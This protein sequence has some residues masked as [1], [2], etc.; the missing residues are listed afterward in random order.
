MIRLLT[1]GL[2]TLNWGLAWAQTA[3]E[4]AVAIVATS[5][6]GRLERT[7][8]TKI[9][10]VEGE[11]LFPGDR[12]QAT[13]TGIEL[14][15]CMSG[16]RTTLSAG[17]TVE[18][19][20][21]GAARKS[22]RVRDTGPAPFCPVPDVTL[23]E[24]EKRRFYGLETL[25]SRATPDAGE[26]ERLEPPQQAALDAE[27]AAIRQTDAAPSYL[28]AAAEAATLAKYGLHEQAA[29]AYR[30]LSDESA[31]VWSRALVY[32][33]HVAS[34]RGVGS[35]ATGNGEGQIYSVLVGINKYPLLA[36]Q[37]LA[38]AIQDARTF[39]D[40]LRSPRGGSV[41]AANVRLL[42]DENATTAAIREGIREV[43]QDRAGPN[44]TAIFFI[45][46]HAGVERKE[47]YILTYDTKPGELPDTALTMREIR[48]LLDVALPNVGNVLIFIDVCHSGQID[49]FKNDLRRVPEF[50][51]R[52]E[53]QETFGILASD[54]DEEAWESSSY[55]NGHG[56]F[57]YFLLQGLNGEADRDSDGR[58]SVGELYFYVSDMVRKG[59]RENQHPRR[60]G[61][62]PGGHLL[63]VNLD[64]AGISLPGWKVPDQFKA[65][66]SGAAE[67]PIPPFTLPATVASPD[68]DRFLKALGEDRL[69]GPDPEAAMELL[70]R[71]R[72]STLD[73]LTLRL[74]ENQLRIALQDRGQQ[75]LLT[76]LGGEEEPQ[77]QDAFE[78]GA[79]LFE[80]AWSL[81]QDALT[82]RSRAWFC[83]ARAM[84]F[85][86]RYDE[87][88][89]LLE[90]ALR[91]EQNAPYLYNALGLLYLQQADYDRSIAAFNDAIRFAP[92]W[93]YPRH[94][95]AL[96][97]TQ[98]GRTEEAIAVY[99]DALQAAP[100]SWF[101][102]Y[103]LGLVQQRI[104]LLRDAEESFRLALSLAP[105]R[106][107]PETA[108]GYLAAYRGHAGD[109]ELFYRAAMA[110]QPTFIPA[111]H[112]LAL[113]LA[114]EG[115][116]PE[117]IAL[118][119]D[120]LRQDPEFYASRLA[121]AGAL[122]SS[123]R[124]EDSLNEY[125]RVSS[126]DPQLVAAS[127]AAAR[128][129]IELD[130][131]PEAEREM[132]TVLA[133]NAQNPAA[134]E[135]LGDALA[136]QARVPDAVDAYRRAAALSSRS[137]GRRLDHKAAELR[138]RRN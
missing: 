60:T 53:G 7:A 52:Y 96:A 8:E 62:M 61:D 84:L 55:G 27:L 129:L 11:L 39:Y 68:V 77:V 18:I 99:R 128:V 4:S 106:P 46:A 92:H 59:T 17:A 135:I 120:I 47:P 43:L 66:Q 38:F 95:L 75:I 33:E 13:G 90:R 16:R 93:S 82:L 42:L 63:P 37:Q 97:L 80:A 14:W 126:V 48:D 20:Q 122:R 132:S 73:P 5:G 116:G 102:A 44:D 138:K 94:N 40:Y 86:A 131:A 2:L 81:D 22:G 49:T 121:L 136:S 133:G 91:L 74:L 25:S 103:N 6:E 30:E 65:R 31:A 26:R 78:T 69:L 111:R 15:H 45:A 72:G 123:G 114:G 32:K 9:A 100:D 117:A 71:L 24:L 134:W 137:E 50:W 85:D 67:E 130:R 58:I 98:T 1:I 125:R 83:Q 79:R 35:A 109:A 89:P 34:A 107:E 12:V 3:E 119:R 113:L 70:P 54:S 115:R 127:L 51:A 76:Y 110:K 124:L 28:K 57:S 118:W 101:I 21:D 56:A 64:G 105:G 104:N 112:D 10:L 23:S 41:P 88:R 108:L 87:A 36:G 29:E 19:Q